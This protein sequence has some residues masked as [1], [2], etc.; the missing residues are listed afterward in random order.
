MSNPTLSCKTTIPIFVL[1]IMSIMIMENDEQEWLGTCVDG[2]MQT[3]KKNKNPQWSQEF[4][5][6]L[7]DAPINERLRIEVMSKSMGF[8]LHFKVR[9]VFLITFNLHITFKKI[10]YWK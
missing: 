2:L 10:H 4:S 1:Q 9:G 8:H 7:H 6:L 3:M 5:W